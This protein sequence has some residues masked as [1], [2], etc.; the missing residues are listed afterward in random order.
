MLK[1]WMCKEF[2]VAVNIPIQGQQ[3]RRTECLW[4]NKPS[5]LQL[6]RFEDN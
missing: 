2:D 3:S 1:G 6:F 5:L 4:I